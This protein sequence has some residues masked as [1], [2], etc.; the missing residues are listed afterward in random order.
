M[1]LDLTL[2]PLNADNGNLSFS[3]TTLPLQTNC[4]DLFD[5]ISE[6]TKPVCNSVD[7]ISGEVNESFTSYL[8]INADTGEVNYGKL[9]ED[10]YGTKLRWVLAGE[11][12]KLSKHEQVLRNPMNKAAFSFLKACPP[13]QKIVLHW[14]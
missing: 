2:L 5:E 6:L 14:S 1:S 12:S 13:K 10:A 11:L 3:H 9:Q 7:F 8:A 4:R